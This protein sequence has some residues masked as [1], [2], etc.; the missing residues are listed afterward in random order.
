MWIIT[1]LIAFVLV[2]TNLAFVFKNY[3]KYTNVLVFSSLSMGLITMLIEYNMVKQWALNND[4]TA[5]LDVLP[6]MNT[7]LIWS[8]VIGILLNGIV[9]YK[10]N[11]NAG[12]L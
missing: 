11:K 6:T 8:I 2:L 4:V 9:V 5:L 7:V 10:S 12:I 1:G 3:Y